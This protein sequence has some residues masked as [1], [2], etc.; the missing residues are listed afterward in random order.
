MLTRVADARVV[1]LDADL[2]GLG[3]GDFNLLDAEVLAG[4]P[5]NGG[6]G[7]VC[8]LNVVTSGGGCGPRT[9]H[10]I[11]YGVFVSRASAVWFGD[12]TFPTVSADMV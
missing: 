4:F 3:R 8:Q 1:D 7:V 11:V 2:V 6:L 10:L 9:L 12:L 5:G